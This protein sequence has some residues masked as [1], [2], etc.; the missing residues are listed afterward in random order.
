M[1]DCDTAQDSRGVPH[2]A[3]MLQKTFSVHG[4]RDARV[5]V[6]AGL[7]VPGTCG[8]QTAFETDIQKTATALVDAGYID[9]YDGRKI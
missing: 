5:L 8:P 6:L 2:W 1:A 9:A 7:A 3:C 4:L